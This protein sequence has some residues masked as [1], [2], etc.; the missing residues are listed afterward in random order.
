MSIFLN[1]G[2]PMRVNFK[3]TAP[4]ET[5]S[6]QQKKI[7]IGDTALKA[8]V[9]SLA[10][11]GVL[12]AADVVLCKGKHINKLTGQN[13]KLEEALNRA[14]S[15][16]TNLS[17]ALGRTTKAENDLAAVEAELRTVQA[18]YK[19]D[20]FKLQELQDAVFLPDSLKDKDS[21][22]II[23]YLRKA[24]LYNQYPNVIKWFQNAYA[25]LA[26]MP[27]EAQNYFGK[28]IKSILHSNYSELQDTGL[29]RNFEVTPIKDIKTP[30]VA[31]PAVVS[32]LPSKVRPRLKYPGKVYVPESWG[33][34]YGDDIRLM[35]N[36]NTVIRKK[37]DGQTVLQA[38]DKEGNLI[39]EKVK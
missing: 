27:K 32:A 23:T 11:L 22:E 10:L 36:G 39:K 13:G 35:E 1:V 5:P 2:T 7:D 31:V 14:T 25:E 12:G 8:G 15:A 29:M 17:E 18:D 9:G 37:V 24:T 19:A 34:K 20:S 16:E 28:R 6:Q 33:V 26:D 3:G 4:Q 21:D 30:S 38:Y